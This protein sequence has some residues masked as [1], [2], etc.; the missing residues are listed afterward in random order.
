MDI[1]LTARELEL[2][3]IAAHIRNDVKEA[4]GVTSKKIY[5]KRGEWDTHYMGLCAEIAVAKVLETGVYLEFGLKGDSGVGDLLVNGWSIQVKCG[6]KEGYRYALFGEADLFKADFGV[7]VY[8]LSENTY[9]IHGIISR[10]KFRQESEALDWG[11]GKTTVAQPELFTPLDS[12]M[13]QRLLKGGKR[14]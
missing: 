11:Y 1:T 5:D 12:P 2:A 10:K 9:R 4:R 14:E 13:V 3:R 8:L 6:A 7:L